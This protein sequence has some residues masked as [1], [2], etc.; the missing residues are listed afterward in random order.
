[1]AYKYTNAATLINIPPSDDYRD[2][3][4]ENLNQEF[5]N[6][7]TWYSIQEENVF[8]SGTFNDVDVRINRA[9]DSNT[10]EKMGDDWKEILFKDLGHATGLGFMY[11]FN[12][13]YWVVIN[14]EITKNLAA[15][16]VVRRCNNALRWVDETGAYY[17]VPCV[18]DM[19]IKQNLDFTAIS[20]AFVLPKGTIQIICQYN[21]T[22]NRI[23]PNQRFLF[24]NANNWTAWKVTGGGLQNYNNLQTLTN[25]T[26][27]LITLSLERNYENVDTDDL[28]NG[29]ARV[30]GDVYTITLNHST[31]S[32][33]VA[34]TSQLSAVVKLNDVTVTRTV[35]WSSGT[36]AKATVSSSGLVTGVAAGNSTVTC[37]LYGN[38][39]TSATCAITVV[40]SSQTIKEV[41]ASP[42]TNYILEGSSQTY[43][44]YLYTNGTIQADT[45]TFSVVAGNVPSTN[46]SLTIING[47]SFTVDNI[48]KYMDEPLV[49][50]CVSGTNTKDVSILLKGVY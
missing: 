26:P 25:T 31:L 19:P 42:S 16:C 50:H 49:I 10:G 40:A 1:M 12:S 30:E 13:N 23:K 11:Y 27:G 48:G 36:I 24:G 17:S 33:G 37:F 34:Q 38:T 35:V 20:S 28:T 44:V 18:I 29:V 41:I 5:Y 43:T 4:Q 7:T 3:F 6:A 9:I 22:S 46:Y 21:T 45:F 47:N 14:S 39:G 32:V 15:G 2:L 8:A